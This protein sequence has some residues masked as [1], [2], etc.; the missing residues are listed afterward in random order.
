MGEQGGVPQQEAG[1]EPFLGQIRRVPLADTAE[2][3]GRPRVW[4]ARGPL[5]VLPARAR[6]RGQN[7]RRDLRHV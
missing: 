3:Q 6:R 5:T 7:A 4:A 2:Q 1:A